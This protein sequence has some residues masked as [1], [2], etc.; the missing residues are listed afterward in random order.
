[1][2]CTVVDAKNLTPNPFPRGKGDR[3]DS[4][5]GGSGV[6]SPFVPLSGTERGIR[7]KSKFNSHEFQSSHHR[8]LRAK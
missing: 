3:K 5:R 1:M 2:A 4:G 6:L 7:D 8:P